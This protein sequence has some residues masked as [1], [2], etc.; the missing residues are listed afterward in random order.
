VR[1][2]AGEGRHPHVE[3]EGR[4][5]R[6]EEGRGGVPGPAGLPAG[7]PRPPRRRGPR[8]PPNVAPTPPPPPG[9]T[10]PPPPPPRSPPPPPP[11]RPDHNGSVG[12]VERTACHTRRPAP[13]QPGRLSKIE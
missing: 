5:A 8:P 10:T 9:A 13:Q 12:W 11:I 4:E 3:Q 2:R 6:R 7:G 1:R